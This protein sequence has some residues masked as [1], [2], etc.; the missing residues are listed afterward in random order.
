[1]KLIKLLAA[2]LGSV[3]FACS[4]SADVVYSN[5]SLN[6]TIQG[7]QISPSQL[8]SDSFTLMNATTLT[9]TTLGL[10]TPSN[11]LP[12]SLTWSIGLSPFGSELGTGSA[13]LS[14]TLFVSYDAFDVYLSTFD[15]NVALAAGD[16]W[17][18][19]SNGASTGG[20][21]LGWDINFGPSLAFYRN[22]D[23]SGTA[24]SEY[25]QLE[26]TGPSSVPEP[27]SLALFAGGLAWV[28]AARRRRMA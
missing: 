23:D 3:V 4:A 2:V 11:A 8:V 9:R 26:G 14:N 19:L 1:M 15:F 6:G 18:T 17:L 21:S 27:G 7:A 5:G 22:D 12:E 16:Y 24:P 25:F 10:W 28:A 20:G 13:L